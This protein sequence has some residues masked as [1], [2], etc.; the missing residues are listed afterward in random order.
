MN[1][2]FLSNFNRYKGSDKID[3][4]IK[5]KLELKENKQTSKAETGL[6]LSKKLLEE[7]KS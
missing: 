3:S 5:C 7:S 6:D 1:F 2:N 4:W